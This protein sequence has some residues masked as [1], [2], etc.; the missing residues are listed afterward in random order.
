M[1]RFT[2]PEKNRIRA[3][4]RALRI[5]AVLCLSAALIT[6]CT[7]EAFNVSQA[8]EKT[9]GITSTSEAVVYTSYN[10]LPVGTYD[11]ADTAILKSINAD[12]RTVTL[13]NTIAAKTYTL[14]YDGT[15][16]A[17]DKYG[18]AMSMAQMTDGTIVDV[19]FYKATRQLVN[20]QVSPDAWIYDSVT[21]YDLGGINSTASI[22][23]RTYALTKGV[24]VFSEGRQTD[25]M[26]I[27]D[28]DSITVA[29]IGYDIYSIKVS[30][31]HGY[32]RLTGDEALVGG[33]V[34]IGGALIT[35]VTGPGMLLTVPEGSYTVR[36]YNDYSSVTQEITVERNQEVVLD[37]SGVT[38]PVETMGSI[39]FHVTPEHAT[40]AL[41]GVVQDIS[42]VVKA[43]Y[44]VHQIEVYASG[45]D[46]LSRYVNVGTELSEI[47]INLDESI[48]YTSGNS[49]GYSLEDLLKTLSGNTVSGNSAGKKTTSGNSTSGNTTSGNKSQVKTASGKNRV[50]I[51]APEG[52]EVYV[53]GLY[54]GLTPMSFKKTAGSHTIVLKKS[55]YETRSYTVYLYDDGEDMSISFSEL[56]KISSSDD[57]GG[58]NDQ[59]DTGNEGNGGGGSSGGNDN[60]EDQGDDSGDEQ[61]NPQDPGSGDTGGDSGD[62][63]DDSGDDND[64]GDTEIPGDPEGDDP[65]GDDDPGGVQDPD[66]TGGE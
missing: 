25:L 34:E 1:K 13:Y 19:N 55:G 53:D 12:D 31:G 2:G 10:Y 57:N 40:L 22:G 16:Y 26:N 39:L 38:P 7:P 61:E 3:F 27:V 24:Q 37:C 52:V 23:D 9:D 44:G 6:A 14:N 41:D 58:A 56:E 29:G 21:K 63:S 54:A 30:S 36:M 4:G 8:Q 51:N 17:T 66:D 45:Y 35:K 11:S 5:S 59:T 49:S 15:T 46:T 62:G 33:W 43:E 50:Y 28:G 18:T 65:T 32:V 64:D 48:A 60:T 20:I 47:T 42:R